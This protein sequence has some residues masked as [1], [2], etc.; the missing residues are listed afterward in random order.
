MNELNQIIFLEAGL[1]WHLMWLKI[2]LTVL[3][4][5][6]DLRSRFLFKI[7]FSNL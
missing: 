7:S 5:E 3:P 2:F 6:P 1:F 4:L